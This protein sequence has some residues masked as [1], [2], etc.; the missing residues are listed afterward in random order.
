[1]YNTTPGQHT[2]IY[3][4]FTGKDSNLRLKIICNILQAAGE[5]KG[6]FAII[7]RLEKS[8]NQYFF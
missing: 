2:N 6:I 7:S 1:M 8:D 3:F 4:Y 5:T